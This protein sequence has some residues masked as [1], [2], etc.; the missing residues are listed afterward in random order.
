M[1]LIVSLS[2]VSVQIMSIVNAY[3]Q[4]VL[5]SA[6]PEADQAVVVVLVLLA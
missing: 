2:T 4:G 1:H 6:R 5:V 3:L